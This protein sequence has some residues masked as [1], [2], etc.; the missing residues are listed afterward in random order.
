M[1]LLFSWNHFFHTCTDCFVHPPRCP[2]GCFL[3]GCCGMWHAQNMQVSI[4]W[5]LP[6]KVLWTH[7][8]V[9]LAPHLVVG[10]VV[11]VDVRS[12]LRHMVSKTWIFFSES[13]SKVHVSQQQR[14]R[15]KVIGDLES[16]NLLAKLMVLHCQILFSAAIAT[17]AEASL[18]WIS[19][20]QVPSL[21]TVSSRCLKL[22]IFSNFWQSC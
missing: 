11:W 14:R 13:A 4:S 10:L 6:E 19:P 12:F 7:K 15:M 17:I 1:N 16:L 9:N 3:R 18:M 20:E 22:V 8:E 21:Q 5:Q 2:E